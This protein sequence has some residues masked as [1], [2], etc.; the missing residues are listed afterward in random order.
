MIV[1]NSRDELNDFVIRNN[2]LKEHTLPAERDLHIN[3]FRFRDDGPNVEKIKKFEIKDCNVTVNLTIEKFSNTKDVD[4]DNYIHNC[5]FVN[6]N[7]SIKNNANPNEIFCFN[8]CNFNNCIVDF[9]NNRILLESC[10][11]KETNAISSESLSAEHSEN[12]ILKDNPVKE[13]VKEAAKEPVKEAAK[14]PVKEAAKEPV[15]EAEKVMKPTSYSYSRD[16]SDNSYYD[17]YSN[18]TE[19][20]YGDSSHTNPGSGGS[21]GGGIPW[22]DQWDK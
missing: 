8:N 21:S 22:Y 15:K 13:A 1:I 7:V 18:S 6:C 2:V 5:N 12:A 16:S 10:S 11:L 4:I 20:S 3:L 9:N 19:Y 17:R 14:E